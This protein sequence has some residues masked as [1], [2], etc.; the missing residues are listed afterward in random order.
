MKEIIVDM[1]TN[2]VPFCIV[3]AYLLTGVYLLMDWKREDKENE[4]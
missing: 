1:A 3:I 2:A 4:K